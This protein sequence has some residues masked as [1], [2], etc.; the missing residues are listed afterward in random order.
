M[1]KL[2]VVRNA[3]LIAGADAVS[4]YLA[5]PL[6][7]P[8]RL[9]AP[10]AAVITGDVA[11]P[12]ILGAVVLGTSAAVAGALAAW[13]MEPGTSRWWGLILS[14]LVAINA[15][16]RNPWRADEPGAT[17]GRWS[18]ILVAAGLAYCGYLIGERLRARR[19]TV[20]VNAA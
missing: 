2:V 17:L 14:I 5:I 18:G 15:Y 12:M 6:W 13:A 10:S 1:S 3:L 7:V 4:V 19:A 8:Y 11:G 20:R 9:V 16:R